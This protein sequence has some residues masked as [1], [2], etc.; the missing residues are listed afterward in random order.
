MYNPFDDYK[1]IKEWF[2]Y[3][4]GNLPKS[5]K[6]EFAKALR[7]YADWVDGLKDQVNITLKTVIISNCPRF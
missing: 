6:E 3:N 1:L 7:R 5:T 2:N 4:E